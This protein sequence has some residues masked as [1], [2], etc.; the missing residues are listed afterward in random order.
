MSKSLD[1]KSVWTPI[2]PNETLGLIWVHT[3]WKGNQQTTLAT[4]ADKKLSKIHYVPN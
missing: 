4:L 3:V 2:R 1:P